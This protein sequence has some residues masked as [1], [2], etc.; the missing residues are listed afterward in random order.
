V[1]EFGCV[2][3]LIVVKPV[4]C[5]LTRLREKAWLA[6]NRLLFIFYLFELR[7]DFIKKFLTFVFDFSRLNDSNLPL[8]VNEIG[9]SRPADKFAADSVPLLTE[10]VLYAL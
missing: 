2:L 9:R 7:E 1:D 6:G 8:F 5:S 3:V 4:A 10:V